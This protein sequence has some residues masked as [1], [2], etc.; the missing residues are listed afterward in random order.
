VR[1][2]INAGEPIAEDSD[3]FGSSVIAAARI[4]AT[5]KGGQVLVSDVVRQLVAGKGFGF[6]DTGEHTLKGLD[7]PV[8]VWEL[9]WNATNPPN[10]SKIARGIG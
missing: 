6:T 9:D 1:I 2:G 5:A 8:R 3:L 10:P 4:A 7:E